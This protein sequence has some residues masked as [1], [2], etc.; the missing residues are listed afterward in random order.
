MANKNPR[1]TEIYTSG[2][3]TGL[4][5]A[6]KRDP[7]LTF[8]TAGIRTDKEIQ[9]FK[10]QRTAARAAIK[11]RD[12]MRKHAPDS[13]GKPGGNDTGSKKLKNNIEVIGARGTDKPDSSMVPYMSSFAPGGAGGGGTY[14]AKVVLD[15]KKVPHARYVIRGTGLYNPNNPGY[16]YPKKA[17]AMSFEHGYLGEKSRSTQSGLDFMKNNRNK[18]LT[19]ALELAYKRKRAGL[20]YEV[21]DTKYANQAIAYRTQGQ[22]PNNDFIVK[23][24]E[25]AETYISRTLGRFSSTPNI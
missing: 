15:Q 18:K 7:E 17:K 24:Q 1:Y 3:S 9:K 6:R 19:E 14:V 20:D 11:A 8:L 16:I 4:K 21:P 22:R 23:G 2:D 12:E 25:K 10:L 13:S 5:L